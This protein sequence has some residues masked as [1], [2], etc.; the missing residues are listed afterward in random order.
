MIL[1]DFIIFGVGR[2]IPDRVWI[3][4]KYRHKFGRF[5]NLKNPRTF[6]EKLQWVK[7]YDRRPE[8]TT[9]VDKYKVKKYVADRIGEEHVIPLL[10]GPWESFEDI[11]FDTLPNQFVLKTNHDCGGVVV[12]KD[13]IKFD[14]KKAKKILSTHL[15]K[16]YYLAYREWPYKNVYPR[17]FAEK[18]MVDESGTELRDYKFFC[19][20]GEPKLMYIATDRTSETEE[21]KFDFF[22]M[23][24]NHLP[25]T[26]GHPN[27]FVTPHR[28]ASFETMKELSA[29]LSK[30]IPQVRVDFYE[31]NGRVF[32]GEF[33]LFHM[34]GLVPFDPEEWDRRIGEWITLPERKER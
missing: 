26:N 18:L 25:F 15:K 21:T 13:K 4:L 11:D 6:N 33:T 29:K 34:S 7:L 27:A 10:G 30:G 17:I 19:F 22:D 1:R 3:Q 5:C 12:C 16:N 31:V 14:K 24:F 2:F 9:M 23:N 28:P 8:Y 32:F 20:N